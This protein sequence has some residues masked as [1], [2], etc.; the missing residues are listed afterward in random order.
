M[1]H[2]LELNKNQLVATL[3]ALELFLED[4]EREEHHGSDPIDPS[5]KKGVEQTINKLNKEYKKLS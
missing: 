3:C 4:C 5:F 1:K 2:S